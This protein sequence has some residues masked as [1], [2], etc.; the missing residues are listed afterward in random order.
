[1]RRLSKTFLLLCL[2]LGGAHNA[3]AATL[4]AHFACQPDAATAAAPREAEAASHV[5]ETASHETHAAAAPT[6][7]HCGAESSPSHHEGA[8]TDKHDDDGAAAAHPARADAPRA[9]TAG[10]IATRVLAPAPAD[11]N[12]CA[13][14]SAPAPASMSERRAD[15][16]RRA[17]HLAPHDA[18]LIASH[19]RLPSSSASRLAPTQHAPPRGVSQRLLFSVF[20]I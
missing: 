2:A 11:C 16:P 9:V 12:H 10:D 8:A 17:P 3:L 13:G 15:A 1:M 5:A 4:C 19:P 14:R 20:L 7:H 18:S 6:A